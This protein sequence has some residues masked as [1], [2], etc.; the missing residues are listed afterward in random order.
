MSEHAPK[1]DLQQ[2]SHGAL[3]KD[4][5]ILS[6]LENLQENLNMFQEIGHGTKIQMANKMKSLKNIK[7]NHPVQKSFQS[8]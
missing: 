8:T 2:I 4:P 3:A 1:T 5:N 7:T 6:N